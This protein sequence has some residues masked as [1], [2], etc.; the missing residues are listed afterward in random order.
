[1]GVGTIER[2]ADKETAAAEED[3]F[4][5]GFFLCTISLEGLR[6]GLAHGDDAV[7]DEK[8][9]DAGCDIGPNLETTNLAFEVGIGIVRR[10][11]IRIDGAECLGMSVS[12]L[13]AGDLGL[14]GDMHTGVIAL[15]VI[16]LD[17]VRRGIYNLGFDGLS[18]AQSDDVLCMAGDSGQC[19]DQ[20]K[21]KSLH[22][23]MFV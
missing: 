5:A 14:G 4:G 12:E 11:E 19:N 22:E 20:Q 16:V 21:Q 18:I 7:S 13:D 17:K 1:M 23:E 15:E 3:A 10:I 8:A 6:L 9:T 2:K